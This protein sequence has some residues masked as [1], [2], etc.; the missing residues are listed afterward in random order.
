MITKTMKKPM[1]WIMAAAIAIFLLAAGAWGGMY[2]ANHVRIDSIITLDVNPSLE[3]KTN[4]RDTVLE[5][6]AVNADATMVLDGMALEG[7]N[8]QTALNSIIGSMV[9]LEYLGNGENKIFIT[10][11]NLSLIHIC[12]G[13]LCK[14]QRHHRAD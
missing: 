8:L 12:K 4:K 2:Y 13:Y 7:V 9:R 11:Q 6:R 1:I 10:V 14:K 3:I 5:V